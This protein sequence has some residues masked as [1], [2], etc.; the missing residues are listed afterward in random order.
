MHPG[1]ARPSSP[2]RPVPEGAPSAT[3][4]SWGAGGQ[5]RWEPAVLSDMGPP[6]GG[7]QIKTC[8]YVTRPSWWLQTF[9][10]A[11]GGSA[12]PRA[13]HAPSVQKAVPVLRESAPRARRGAADTRAHTSIQ[14]G[15]RPPPGKP[16][17]AARGP[18]PAAG[19]NL[20]LKYSGCARDGGASGTPA[21]G[22]PPKPPS[23]RENPSTRVRRGSHAVHARV[24][25]VSFFPLPTAVR[26]R[27][28]LRGR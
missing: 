28:H 20:E 17:W 11:S 22:D 21:S 7:T 27:A 1:A 14:V 9:H 3:G 12:Q 16:C 4:V 18:L 26:Q 8:V 19:S 25:G 5:K 13:L 24:H 6:Q 10:T 15:G 2:P 23:G